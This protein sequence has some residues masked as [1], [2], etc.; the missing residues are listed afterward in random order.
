MT[1]FCVWDSMLDNKLMYLDMVE[2]E[3]EMVFHSLNSL[4][5]TVSE[6]AISPSS[7]HPDL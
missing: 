1:I 3:F 7:V 2:T 6:G 4:R 5:E